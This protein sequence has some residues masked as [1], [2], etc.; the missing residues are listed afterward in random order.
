[1]AAT[2]FH[3]PTGR[4]LTYCF[5]WAEGTVVTLSIGSYSKT[6]TYLSG[7][8]MWCEF[9]Q[10]TLVAPVAFDG[11]TGRP[12]FDLNECN[13]ICALDVSRLRAEAA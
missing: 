12:L 9:T 5:D 8:P 7:K 13:P 4:W 10:Y 6:R 11:L 3:E 1:M 2:L